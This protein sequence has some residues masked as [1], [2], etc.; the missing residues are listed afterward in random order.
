MSFRKIAAFA[1]L[2][3]SI[4]A[5]HGAAILTHDYE[6]NGSLSDALGGPSLVSFGGTLGGTGYT[7]GANQ[8]LSLSNGF[9]NAGNYSIEMGFSFDTTGGFRKILDFKN[10]TSD[11]GLY[12]LTH[13]LNFFPI[14]TGVGGQITDTTFVTVILTRDSGSTV[15]V[16]YVNGAQQISFTDTTSL[17]VFD[18]ASN[19]AQF[20]RD[21]FATGQ[22]EASSGFVDFIRVY[23]GA[24]TGNQ[25]SCLQGSNP[26]ACNIP[27]A[28]GNQSVP[29]P[30]SLAL[31]GLGLLGF[32]ARKRGAR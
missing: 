26:L 3:G 6:L 11:N 9:A 15:A 7:F 2:A 28:V 4:G 20:F 22:G 16:G 25:A 8:G 5:A 21:D 14:T 17:A 19:I 1:V 32:F 23:D 31:L 18:A 10:R 27:G 13:N 30:G 12:N 29:E 24:L